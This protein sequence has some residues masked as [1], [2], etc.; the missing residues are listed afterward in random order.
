ML[1]PVLGGVGGALFY[2]E[3][4]KGNSSFAILELCAIL[5]VF[6]V[7]LHFQN[8]KTDKYSKNQREIADLN[9]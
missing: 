6:I 8:K 4:Y 1:G 2:Q 3:L 5:M 9:L 7:I